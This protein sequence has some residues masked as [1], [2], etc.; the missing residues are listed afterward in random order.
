MESYERYVEDERP[1]PRPRTRKD[2]ATGELV[3]TAPVEDAERALTLSWR[4]VRMQPRDMQLMVERACRNLPPEVRRDVTPHGLRH[5]A[6]T[7]LLSS[8]AAD[9]KTVKELLGH[10]SIAT[11][12]VYLYTVADEMAQAVKAHPVTGDQHRPAGSA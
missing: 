8:G 9:I 7:L 1:D 3:Q 5:T 6:A 2:P 10:A 4:G 12:G 11:T